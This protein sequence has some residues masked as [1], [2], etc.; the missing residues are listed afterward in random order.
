[1]G[2]NEEGASLVFN[3][4]VPEKL[5]PVLKSPPLLVKERGIK[6]TDRVQW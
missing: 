5:L 6:G 2:E 3:R 1:M 4:V